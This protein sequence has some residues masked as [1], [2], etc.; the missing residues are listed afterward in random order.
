MGGC[1]LVDESEDGVVKA[2][3]LQGFDTDYFSYGMG[4]TA[5]WW[6]CVFFF[7]SFLFGSCEMF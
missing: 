2:G 5:T 4:Q 6:F 7:F 1:G 3:P